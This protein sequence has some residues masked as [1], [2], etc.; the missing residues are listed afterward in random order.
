MGLALDC[1]PLIREHFAKQ[2]CMDNGIWHEAHIRLYEYLKD[3]VTII[4]IFL[5]I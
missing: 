1:H 5:K 4:R 2:L 3:S